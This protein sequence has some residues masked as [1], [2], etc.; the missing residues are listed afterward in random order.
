VTANIHGTE[1]IRFH[2]VTLSGCCVHCIVYSRIHLAD[3]MFLL[4][5]AQST[6]LCFFSNHP[7]WDPPAPSTAGEC[8]PPSFGSAGCGHTRLRVRG[9]LYG[10]DVTA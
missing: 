9:S 2:K 7:N 6:V 8:F 4:Y 10:V 3:F 1:L 5:I